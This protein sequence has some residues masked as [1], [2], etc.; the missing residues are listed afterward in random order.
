M[1]YEFQQLILQR[2]FANLAKYFIDPVSFLPPD[3]S[4]YIDYTKTISAT[5]HAARATM[6]RIWGLW[7][8]GR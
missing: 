1:L 8:H 2:H 7:C 5:L 4:N 3:M 6:V